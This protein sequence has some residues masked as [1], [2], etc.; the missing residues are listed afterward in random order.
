V[1]LAIAPTLFEVAAFMLMYVVVPN[2]RVRWRHALIGSVVAAILFEVAKRG[3][4]WF[5][6]SFATYRVIYGALAVL[7]MFL[8][9]IYLSWMVVLLGAVVTAALPEWSAAPASRRRRAPR[10]KAATRP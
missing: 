6:L 9:W 4:A 3:F 7:P 10:K 8:V 2:H 1:I 5:V